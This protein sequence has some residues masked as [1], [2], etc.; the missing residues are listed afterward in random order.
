MRLAVRALPLLILPVTLAG[1]SPT[2]TVELNPV[3]VTATR[4]PTRVADLPVAVTVV[5]G[6]RLREQG[7]RTVADALRTIPGITVVATNAF[8]SQTSLFLRGGES[9]YVKVLIDGVPQNLPGGAY[10]FANLTTDNVER[11]EVVRGPAS[12]LYGSDAVTGVVQIFTRDGRGAAHAGVA[13]TGGTYGSS[14]VDATLTGG[15]ERAG[16]A[17]GMSR[18]SSDG[19]YPIDNQYRNAVLSARLRVRPTE[20]TDAAVS[21]RYGDALYHFPTDGG[22]DPVSNN[23]HQLERGPSVGLDIGHLFSTRVEGRLAADWRRANYQY[24]IGANGPSDST[25]FPFSSSDWVTRTGL[26]GRLNVRLPARDVITA[27]ATVER[28]AMTGTTLDSARS[29]N[30]GALYV[31]LVTPPERPIG[32]TLGGRLEENQRFGRYATYRTGASMRVAAGTRAIASVGTGFKEP[33]FY[34]TFATGF[35][36]GNAKLR[37]EHSLSWEA[38]LEYAAPGRTAILR[39]TYFHQRFRDLIQYSPVGLGPDSVNYR[40]VA[41]AMARGVELAIQGALGAG[42]SLDATYTYLGSRDVATGQRLQRRPSHSGSLRLGHVVGGRGTTSLVAVFTGDRDDYDYSTFPAPRVTLPPHTRVDLS[43]LYE[44]SRGRGTL[45]GVALTVRIE[46]VLGARYEDVKNFPARGRTLLVG[47][48]LG[49]G[50]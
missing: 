21:L 24:A 50:P 48:R 46:N 29:R 38:G 6:E 10:D 19:L 9:D 27:G 45:P 8:G 3:V 17:L 16:Y 43:S 18:F 40:N 4:I 33:S 30:N 15:G 12:V 20:R 36:R 44:V 31:Q 11:I 34:E 28:Q 26:D 39:A 32:L 22:G 7:I 37:P 5:G 13:V 14:A 42:L 25:T 49:W 23:Q 1:Q 2:D 47:G 35:V 41:D